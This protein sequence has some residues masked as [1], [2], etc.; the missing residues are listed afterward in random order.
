L[1]VP[2]AAPQGV[3]VLYVERRLIPQDEGHMNMGVLGLTELVAGMVGITLP[4]AKKI[5]YSNFSPIMWK[6]ILTMSAKQVQ[7]RIDRALFFLLFLSW[8]WQ[9]NGILVSR[10]TRADGNDVPD[11]QIFL[12]A[13]QEIYLFPESRLRQDRC[14]ILERCGGQPTLRQQGG[15]CQTDYDLSGPGTV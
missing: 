3:V 14:G 9:Y 1:W 5:R 7:K 15:I 6:F 2:G 13:A 11:D 12:Y 4:H 8:T 10:V